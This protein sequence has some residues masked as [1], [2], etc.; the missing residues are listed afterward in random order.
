MQAKGIALIGPQC[1]SKARSTA[2][3]RRH[4]PASAPLSTAAVTA[5]AAASSKPAPAAAASQSGRDKSRLLL[6]LNSRLGGAVGGGLLALLR[7]AVGLQEAL[8]LEGCQVML[9]ACV[10]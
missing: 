4:E 1:N 10:S 2:T 3:P 6:G 7:V 5:A 9:I 8:R